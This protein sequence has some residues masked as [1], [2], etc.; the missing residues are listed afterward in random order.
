MKQYDEIE[1]RLKQELEA[2]VPDVYEKIRKKAEEQKPAANVVP[3]KK[4]EAKS[5]TVRK[6]LSVAA[7]LIVV[8]TG[9]FAYLGSAN[10][11]TF[12]VEIDVNPGVILEVNKSKKMQH[13]SRV[14]NNYRKFP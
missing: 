8:I 12:R 10:A 1:N 14:P 9:V 7:V 13:C 5:K 4:P 6:I 3:L 2:S 11:S